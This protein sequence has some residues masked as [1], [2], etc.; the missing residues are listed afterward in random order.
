MLLRTAL[1]ALVL[2]ASDDLGYGATTLRIPPGKNILKIVPN[3]GRCGSR[4]TP[5]LVYPRP[6]SGNEFLHG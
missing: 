5:E 2:A 1:S 3:L 4:G 6:D